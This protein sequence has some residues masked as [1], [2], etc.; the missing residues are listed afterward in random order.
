[1]SKTLAWVSH[2]IFQSHPVPSGH[3]ESPE[4]LESAHRALEFSGVAEKI[5]RFEATP[6]TEGQ[7]QRVHTCE[8]IHALSR[9]TPARGE[10]FALDG[11]TYLGSDTYEAALRAA[12]AVVLGADIVMSG[13]STRAFCPVRPPGHHAERHRAM[14]FCLF[15]N[16]AVGAAHAL[17]HHKLQRV[18]II[19][20]D[21]HHGNGTQNIFADDERVLFCSSFQHPFYP[22]S[23]TEP[24]GAHIVNIPLPAGTSGRVYRDAVR[25]QWLPALEAFR[26]ELIFVS[27]GFDGHREDPLAQFLLE[28]DDY[29]WITEFC[30]NAADAYAAGRLVSVMEGGYSL[31]A[32]ERC[33][34]RHVNSL[35]NYV[36]V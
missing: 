24:A 30:I 7:L 33:V 11:D 36:S 2:P 9:L 12:G 31:S 20:F 22:F 8:H 27:A 17:T 18:A 3:P 5:T 13:D 23:G 19:D 21:V 4:R 34:A 35:A 32:L 6:A 29:Q 16:I 26:P 28:D 25:D 1:M 14:G 15:N 10:L